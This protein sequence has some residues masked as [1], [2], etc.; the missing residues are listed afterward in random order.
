MWWRANEIRLRRKGSKNYEII[1]DLIKRRAEI[2]TT[3]DAALLK[4]EYDHISR[5]THAK[6]PAHGTLAYK[7]I[8][9]LLPSAN[10][11]ALATDE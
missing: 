5:L 11:G 10:Y 7:E 3:E 1:L 6:S 2:R 8:E 9:Q 4:E